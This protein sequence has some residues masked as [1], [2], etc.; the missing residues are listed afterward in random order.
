MPGVKGINNRGKYLERRSKIVPE[1][2]ASILAGAPDAMT[3][4]YGSRKPELPPLADRSPS[5]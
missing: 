5:S 4:L 1:W 2:T 3:L